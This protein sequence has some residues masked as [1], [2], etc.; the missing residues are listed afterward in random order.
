MP[1][2]G[3]RPENRP[4]SRGMHKEKCR[5]RLRPASGAPV[6]ANG[7][8]TAAMAYAF[9]Q[10]GSDEKQSQKAAARAKGEQRVGPYLSGYDTSSDQYHEYSVG[11]TELCTL[12]TA[13]C[14]YSSMAPIV[15]GESVPFT[16]FY[17]GE[18][19]YG[20]P[21]GM[22]LDPIIHR[23][24]EPGIWL[25]ITEPGH[26]Y[27]PGSVVHSVH[28]SGGKLWLYSKGAGVGP[29]PGQNVFMGEVLFGNMHIDVQNQIIQQQ[30]GYRTPPW[31]P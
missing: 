6:F 21:Y 19:G 7:A 30:T 28:E 4:L 5:H 17:S 9:N 13:G 31:I 2:A 12:S 27:H 18:G 1:W 14:S 10:L 3:L 11:P 15:G 22:G 26:R 24:P 20:L 8:A 23:T 16:L 25:N 29:N